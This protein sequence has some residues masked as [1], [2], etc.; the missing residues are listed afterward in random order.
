MRKV[1]TALK[2]LTKQPW[3]WPVAV[4]LSL[5]LSYATISIAIDTGSMLQW[6]LGFSWLFNAVYSASKFMQQRNNK[7]NKS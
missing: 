3:Y 1:E 2:H 6:G 4:V 5:L 7:K